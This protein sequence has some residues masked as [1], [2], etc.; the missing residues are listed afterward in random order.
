M[1]LSR[2]QKVVISLKSEIVFPKYHLTPRTADAAFCDQKVLL[3]ECYERRPW[4][5]QVSLPGR[6]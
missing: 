5:V 1:L 6:I 2:S 3:M 4:G